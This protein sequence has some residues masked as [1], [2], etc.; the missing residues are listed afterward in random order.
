MAPQEATG[1]VVRLLNRITTFAA[2]QLNSVPDGAPLKVAS[3]DEVVSRAKTRALAAAQGCS[4]GP[5][6]LVNWHA[7][8][9]VPVSVAP[10]WDR[11][12]LF[13]PNRTYWMLGLTGD[14]GRSLAEFMI[15]R[16]ARHVV[17]SSRTPKPDKRWIER[18]QH[19]YGATVVYI[20]V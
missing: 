3:L 9:Q 13:R 20:A 4:T 11:D 17:L 1:E 6:C 12:D 2:A 15:S 7:E 19:I 14:L 18:Q 8:N 10:V 16:R 5:F